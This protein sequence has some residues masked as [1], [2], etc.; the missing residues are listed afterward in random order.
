MQATKQLRERLVSVEQKGD[1]GSLATM[2]LLAQIDICSGDCT[3]FETHLKGA[4]SLVKLRGSDGTDRCFFEQRLVWLDIMGSTT[5]PRMPHLNSVDVKK[6]LD[7]FNTTSGREWGYDV[8]FCPID[9]FEYI[10]D[11]TMLYKLQHSSSRSNQDTLNKA[12]QLG[13][14]VQAWH[15]PKY[16]SGPRFHIV[17]AWRAGILI[18]LA[19]LFDLPD[20]VFEVPGLVRLTVD[21]VKAIPSDTPWRNSILW[22]L[23][24]AGLC[25]SPGDLGHDVDQF[26]ARTWIRDELR[27][28]FHRIGCGHPKRALQALEKVWSRSDVERRYNSIMVGILA[29]R[30]MLG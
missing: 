21:H 7:K 10:A 4:M 14:G 28:T 2:L 20:C 8:F 23:F 11:I 22:P 17:E 24:Q 29:H 13:A 25:L 3:E 5:T 6:A 16:S 18:Y 26:Q 1:L 12:I 15:S 27:S 9:L 19:C 30:L